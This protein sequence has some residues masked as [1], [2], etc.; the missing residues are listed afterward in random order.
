MPLFSYKAR[1][2]AGKPIS[3][4][5]DAA[6]KDDLM[7]KLHKM[8][9]LATQIKELS[10]AR[11]TGLRLAGLNAISDEDMIVFNVELANMVGSGLSLLDSLK[12]LSKQLENVK[13]KNTVDQIL[14]NITA[15]ESFSGA[16]LRYPRVFSKFFVNMVKAGETSGKLGNVLER[17]AEYMESQSMLKQKIKEIVL[18]PLIVL[19]L[20]VSVT[21]FLVTFVIPRFVEIFRTLEIKLPLMTLILYKSGLALAH[22]WYVGIL[23]AVAVAAGFKYFVNTDKGGYIY[24]RMKLKLPVVG[25]LYRKIILSRFSRTLATLFGSGVSILDSLRITRDIMGN[26]IYEKCLADVYDAVRKGESISESLAL[27]GEFPPDVIQMV[28]VGEN[29]GSLQ[30]MLNKISDL[31][32]KSISYAVKKFTTV[33]EPLILVVVGGIVGFIMASMLLP[34]FNLV[35]VFGK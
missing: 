35:K 25:P 4:T 27:T 32:D 31:Y 5:M 3:S 33:I 11:K 16:L 19:A 6:D 28:S 9:Y 14:T 22:F 34:I 2:G 21:I 24:D 26:R 10:M 7:D 15:G 17:V 29:S 8:G 1:D 30:E 12:V 18:Y 23:V 13:L 20:A